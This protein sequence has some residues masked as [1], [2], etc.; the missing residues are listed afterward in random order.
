MNKLKEYTG[1]LFS[2]LKSL[3]RGKIITYAIAAKII[4]LQNPRNIGWI[5][6]QNDAPDRTPCYKVIR[7]DGRLAE[8]YKFGGR[9]KQKQRLEEEGMTFD[10][11]DRI[12]DFKE[13]TES[14]YY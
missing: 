3:P 7:S 10:R 6:R 14:N 9:E 8:G 5:L 1:P 2:L 4:G 13:R 12:I 11:N